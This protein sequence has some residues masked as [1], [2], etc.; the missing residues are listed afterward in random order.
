M[1]TFAGVHKLYKVNRYGTLHSKCSVSKDSI[2]DFTWFLLILVGGFVV[3]VVVIIFILF[4]LF[5]KSFF[6]FYYYL[7]FFTIKVY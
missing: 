5:F 4:Y 6:Y 7:F 3:V 1:T 2:I